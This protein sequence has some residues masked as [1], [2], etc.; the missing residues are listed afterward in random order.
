MELIGPYL[1]GCTLLVVAGAMKA[2]RPDDTARAL[3]PL[4]PARLGALSPF[5]R[6]RW[7]IRSA[8]VVEAGLGVVAFVLPRAGSAALV[9]ASYVA[10]AGGVA[11]ARSR[12]GALASCGC[13]GTPDTPA[14]LL[15]VVVDLVFAVAAASVA[16]SAPS[17]GT[18]LTVLAHQPLHGVA[19]LVVSAVGA[20]LT[21]LTLTM[22]GALQAAR[23]AVGVHGSQ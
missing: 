1:I 2:V 18:I 7:I 4:M 16:T 8:A 10:F 19:L 13:F 22:L 14:T 3:A 5:G 21:Y 17:E 9:A 15:H 6:L 23:R 20:W 11:Y 12:G